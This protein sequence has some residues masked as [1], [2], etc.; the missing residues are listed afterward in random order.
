MP[1]CRLPN[2]PCDATDRFVVD[3]DGSV[4]KGKL[5]NSYL[6]EHWSPPSGC[7][8]RDVDGNPIAHPADEDV[9][10]PNQ[11]ADGEC[12]A[13]LVNGVQFGPYATDQ[14]TP[15]DANFGA[16]V[17]GNYGF[18]DVCLAPGTLDDSDPANP[19]CQD[20]TDPAHPDVP[21][22]PISADSYLV[23]VD[24]PDDASGNPEYSVTSEEDINI[25]RGDT[26]VPQVPPP[27]CA[28]AL[29]TVDV[30]DGVPATDDYPAVTG[31]GTNGVPA[32]VTVPTSTPVDN[33]TL[34]RHRRVALRGH[35]QAPVR[36]QAGRPQQRQVDRA[37]VPP[38][39]RRPGAVAT[40]RPH[41]R[42]PQLRGR[43]AGHP[44]R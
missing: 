38:L 25:G 14:E 5:L 6:S 16:T 3:T 35:G 30:L 24:I 33:A 11:S 20:L 21:F 12:V 41:R 17:D 15:A 28:G 32:G 4:K 19:T 26:V 44:V 23:S 42:R 7:T 31:N 10:S 29:H 13:A 36:H 37:D 27:S 40:A 22:T 8:A 2:T 9:L 34:R 1:G 43:Q 18:G 39:H